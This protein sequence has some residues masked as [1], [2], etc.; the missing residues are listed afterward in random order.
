[1]AAMLTFTSTQM[2]FWSVRLQLQLSRENNNISR[3]LVTSSEQLFDFYLLVRQQDDSQKNNNYL[4]C[5][6]SP[7]QLCKKGNEGQEGI[8]IWI[9]GAEQ[10]IFPF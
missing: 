5:F 7:K 6:F 3:K 10:A 9:K 1:M 8:T 4:T 2:L